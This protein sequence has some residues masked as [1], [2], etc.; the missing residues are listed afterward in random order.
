[1]RPS[2]VELVIPST[3][4]LEKIYI[5]F[6]EGTYQLLIVSWLG[7]GTHVNFCFAILW[8]YLAWIC[9]CAV[10]IVRVSKFICES[11]LLC[12]ENIFFGVIY[13]CL[14]QSF[15]LFSVPWRVWFMKTFN[16]GLN[17]LTSLSP[18]IL[19]SCLHLG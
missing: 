19:T 6:P 1:M 15:C 13:L 3:T 14:L 9:I 7:V 10:H 17:V 11:V 5:C 8:S 18:C 16:L 12:M 2:G 4:S